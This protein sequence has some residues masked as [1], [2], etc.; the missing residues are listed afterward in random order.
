MGLITNSQRQYYQSG[1]LGNYQFTSLRDIIDQFMVV[2]VGEGKAISKASKIDVAF[3]AQRAMQELSFDTFK[4]V[5][6]QE[7]KLPPTLIMPLPQDYV[8]YVK[9]TFSDDA[10]IEHVLYPTNKTSNPFKI[11]QEIDGSY[12]FTATLDGTIKN[13]SFT[14]ALL[15]TVGNADDGWIHTEIPSTHVDVVQADAGQLKI[16]HSRY[17]YQGSG[18]FS[19]AFCV[20]Q[21]LDV[22]DMV[23][24]TIGA[25]GL[26]AAA[27]ASVKDAGIIR[28]GVTSREPSSSNS[29]TTFDATIAST[30]DPGCRNDQE[31][32]FNLT[33]RNGNRAMAE[34]NDGAETFS[35]K[36]IEDIDV[37]SIPPDASG[38]RYIWFIITSFV[39]NF[40]GAGTVNTS[41]NKLDNITFETRSN[42]DYLQD[43]GQ[44]TTWSNYKSH[45]PS[46]NSINDYQDY[47]NDAYYPNEGERY[48][49][50]PQYAQVN[51]SFYIDELRG[52]IHFSSPLSGKTIILEYISDG[53]GTDEE[54]KVHK[55]AE[56]AMYRSIAFAIISASSYGQSLVRRYKKE[57]F[58]AI[59]QAKLRLSNI[60]LEE[61]TQIFRGKSKQ[62]KH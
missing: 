3:H 25:D 6:S 31:N 55:F 10:G 36:T 35:T 23:T 5:K 47:E 49:L 39:P 19:N 28:F 29:A 4:S 24:I 58:A 52:N 2:Y 21:R 18:L 7:I 44:S 54:M 51:G 1:N 13:A 8:N 33:D 15:G 16:E 59:R 37:L 50:D 46:E 38:K 27:E 41:V 32:I 34:F 22:T 53:L 60:K 61:I 20:W 26:S 43:Q 42:V 11:P 57:K 56:E 14:D 48:G 40:I 12:D 30:G 9:L 62:I 17:N 45:V